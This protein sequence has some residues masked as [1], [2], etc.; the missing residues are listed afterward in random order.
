MEERIFNMYRLLCLVCLGFSTTL[1]FAE[2]L[3]VK[4]ADLE[5]KTTR[6]QASYAVGQ[7]I[8]QGLKNDGLDLNS[9]ALVRGLLDALGGA[10]PKLTPQQ[11]QAALQALSRDVT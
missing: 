11:S 10:A 4:K 7:N 3:P 9:A 6:D 1:V 5:L 8:G 2:D